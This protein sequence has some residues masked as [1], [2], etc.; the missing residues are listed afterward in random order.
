MQLNRGVYSYSS[1]ASELSNALGVGNHT[2]IKSDNDEFYDIPVSTFRGG[3]SA[4]YSSASKTLTFAIQRN[5]IRDSSPIDLSNWLPCCG[6]NVSTVVS[7]TSVGLKP[8]LIV[9]A[10]DTRYTEWQANNSCRS[11][12]FQKPLWAFSNGSAILQPA[13][14]R[15]GGVIPAPITPPETGN[16]FSYELV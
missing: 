7:K 11:I 10:L 15:F 13:S 2:K 6:E 1:V 14:G 3:F 4:S 9:S 12:L 5:Y 16:S 8:D